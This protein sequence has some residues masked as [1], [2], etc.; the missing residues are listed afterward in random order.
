MN[1]TLADAVRRFVE[2]YEGLTPESLAG[3]RDVYADDASFK[4]PFNDV[5]GVEEV[6]RV[7]AHMFD[8][9]SSARFVIRDSVADGDQ[10][11]L[12]WDFYF[13]VRKWKPDVEQHI[14]GASHVRF[15]AAGKAVHH[16]DYWDAAEELYEKLPVMGAL[17]RFL[18]RR[19][20]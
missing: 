5:R 3:I 1:A 10:A 2:F 19:M 11:F 9:L 12:R 17:M 4:D 8:A 16:R 15:D 14:H 20:Q 13:H 6:R 7:L 18:R